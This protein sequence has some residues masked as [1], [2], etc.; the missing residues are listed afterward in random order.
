MH[1]KYFA[2]RPSFDMRRLRTVASK[3]T[4]LFG[5]L[6]IELANGEGKS[7]AHDVY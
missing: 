5:W 6:M 7:F 1:L 2:A 4:D 3:A